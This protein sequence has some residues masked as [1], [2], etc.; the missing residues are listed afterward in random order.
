MRNL[1]Y[2]FI[3]NCNSHFSCE[4]INKFRTLKEQHILQTAQAENYKEISWGL[5]HQIYYLDSDFFQ[6]FSF[7]KRNF[8]DTVHPHVCISIP[9]VVGECGKMS[10]I[11]LYF[12]QVIYY[13]IQ[14]LV[15]IVSRSNVFM[16]KVRFVSALIR[17]P[18][19]ISVFGYSVY[20]FLRI[21]F[22]HGKDR[23]Y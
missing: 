17:M 3:P 11:W 6:F 23:F 4:H 20:H 15:A 9:S 7:V 14:N 1:R 21:V 12:Q 5:S 2:L 10:Y 16:G 8:S 13:N 18:M 22:D 19:L